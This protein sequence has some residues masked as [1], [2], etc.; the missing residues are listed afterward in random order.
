MPFDRLRDEEIADSM[1]TEI[2]GKNIEK[3]PQLE[4]W[5]PR[6]VKFPAE[7]YPAARPSYSPICAQGSS[8]C[9]WR[10]VDQGPSGV[11]SS[12]AAKDAR[13]APG[14]AGSD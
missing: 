11:F 12:T 3:P 14:R 13:A 2:G 4:A 9:S 5:L 1:L 6:W 7:S 10:I 8:R